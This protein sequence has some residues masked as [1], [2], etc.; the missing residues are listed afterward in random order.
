MSRALFGG[1]S[2]F[3]VVLGAWIL[4]TAPGS[5]SAIALVVVGAIA[6]RLLLA[7]TSDDVTPTSTDR[8]RGGT[9]V[10]VARRLGR[11]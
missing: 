1:V 3:A 4:R 11:R 5:W 6:A 7:E 8:A 10:R 9:P 2:I